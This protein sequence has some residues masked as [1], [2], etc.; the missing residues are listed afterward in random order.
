[1]SRW[2]PAKSL[3]GSFTLQTLDRLSF[4]AKSYYRK[5]NV[6]ARIYNGANYHDG[7]MLLPLVNEQNHEIMGFPKRYKDINMMNGECS[8]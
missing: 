2:R 8:I 6:E 1:M 7:G 4:K 5:R 3:C